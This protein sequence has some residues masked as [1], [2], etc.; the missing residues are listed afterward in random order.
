MKTKHIQYTLFNTP[1]IKHILR[2]IALALIKILGWKKYGTL[3]D[4]KQYVAIL[5]FHTSNWDVFYGILMAFAFKVDIYYLAKSQLFRFPFAPLVRFIGGIPIDRSVSSNTV[6]VTINLFKEHSNFAIA[7]AP[8]GTRKKVEK[9]KKGF[10][11]IAAGANVPIVVAFLDYKTK[12]GG[13][14]DII[15]PSGDIKADLLKI[16]KFYQ[17]VTAKY[18]GLASLPDV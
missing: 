5:A 10:Y 12:S 13:I 14:G 7:I 6:D 3:P 18:P 16:K 11:H 9:W 15:Y 4:F 2:I 17:T 8:E 1:I